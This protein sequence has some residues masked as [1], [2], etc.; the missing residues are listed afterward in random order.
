[1]AERAKPEGI[2]GRRGPSARKRSF[3][4]QINDRQCGLGNDK[5]A[6]L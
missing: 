1:M 6:L 5:M 3:L 2:S 4:T